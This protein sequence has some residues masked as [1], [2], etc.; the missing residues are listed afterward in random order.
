MKNVGEMK[1]MRERVKMENGE[2]G[3][4]A[5]AEACTKSSIKSWDS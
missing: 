3:A 1:K 2:R 4:D 5:G